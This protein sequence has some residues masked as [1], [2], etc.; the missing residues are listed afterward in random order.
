MLTLPELMGVLPGRKPPVS[1]H[2]QDSQLGVKPSV[3][4]WNSD[5]RFSASSSAS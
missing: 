5:H 4:R 2:E 3:C 1:Q